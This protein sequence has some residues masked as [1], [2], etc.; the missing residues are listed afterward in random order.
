[1][2]LMRAPEFWHG[3]SGQLAGIVAGLLT[4]LGAAWDAATRL[5]RL[6]AHPYRA[7]V[8]VL[9]VGN[10]VAGGSGKTPVV[11]SLAGR[12]A[13]TGIAPHVVSR[14]YGGRLAG[15]VRVDPLQHD[16]AAVGDEPLLI[17]ARA[18]CWVARDRAAGV[19][20]AVASGAAA[21]LLDDGFQNPAVAKDCSLV[22]IDAEY[23]F[24]NRRVIPAGP[25]REMAAAG[26]ARADAIVLL[27]DA[28][29]PAGVREAGRPV[30][31]AALEAVEGERFAGA[32][33][34]AF[35]GIGRPEKFFASLRATGASLVATH[36]F[37]DHHRFGEGEIARLRDDATATGARL[38]TTAKDWVRLPAHLRAGIE[39]LEVEIG[40][41]DLPAVAH[42]LSDVLHRET[43][44]EADGCRRRAAGF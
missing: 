41:Q 32:R 8:P 13:A 36:P 33:V 2:A 14:G 23:G 44:K 27:G 9:C 18:A 11:L 6:T 28:A 7:P 3:Q 5:R 31:R 35:A 20:A 29:A 37:A 17:A 42:L 1:M 38:V 24:G 15:P 22:V 19:R 39:V 43:P 26:L 10:L 34:I 16:A 12:I 40:W 4:P 30:F 21:I 25:L